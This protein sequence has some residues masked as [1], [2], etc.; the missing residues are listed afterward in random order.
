MARNQTRKRRRKRKPTP[1]PRASYLR[2]L[3]G[4]AWG[5]LGAFAVVISVLQGWPWLAIDE[6]SSLDGKNPYTTL[7]R[8]RNDGYL[9]VSD[10]DAVC[11]V[12][13]IKDN[14][15]NVFDLTNSQLQFATFLSHSQSVTLPCFNT[16]TLQGYT[17]LSDAGDLVVTVK[18][19]LYPLS[20]KFLRK[21]QDFRFRPIQSTDGHWNWLYLN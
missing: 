1:E 3:P 6:G 9:P 16:I 10:L 13:P 14:S 2:K 11:H 4:W 19:S 15:Q 12:T 21:H 5:L 18:Y 17:R 7:F 20:F 8:V